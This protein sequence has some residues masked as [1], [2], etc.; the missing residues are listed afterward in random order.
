MREIKFREWD[1]KEMVM[2]VPLSMDNLGGMS[3][4]PSNCAICARE[5]WK[6]GKV[7]KISDVELMQFTGLKDKNGKEIYEGDIVRRVSI[8]EDVGSVGWGYSE[9]IVCLP[10]WKETLQSFGFPN[11]HGTP[12][13]EVI[14]N[15]YEHS[16]LLNN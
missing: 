11:D 8:K 4:E 3:M 13:I 10:K 5:D 2:F 15:I 7:R 16:H 1:K 12:R 6:D 14:G 9:W